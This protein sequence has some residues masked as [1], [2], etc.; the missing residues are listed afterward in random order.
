MPH[1]LEEVAEIDGVL[2]VNDSKATNVAAAAAALESFDGGVHAILG[3]SLEGRADFERA[4]RRRRRALRAL[5]PDRRGGERLGRSAARRRRRAGPVRRPR[6]RG[7]RGRGAARAGRSR[8][9]RAGLRELRPVPRLR[10]ARRALPRARARSDMTLGRATMELRARGAR[11]RDD[12]RAVDAPHGDAVPD[13]LRRGDGLQREL[14]HVA[15]VPWRRQLV[16]PEALPRIGCA[17]VARAA[18]FAA[19]TALR[20]AQQRSRR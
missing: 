9:A 13:R 2:Y 7:A 18:V 19:R 17:R 6:A 3:G 11:E 10:G 8:A 12:A 15:A 14:G 1:R 5:L 20:F 16:L 4:R